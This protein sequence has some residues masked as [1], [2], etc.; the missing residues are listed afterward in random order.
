[1]AAVRPEERRVP[2]GAVRKSNPR[3]LFLSRWRQ[4]LKASCLTGLLL[5]A[6]AHGQGVP[7]SQEPVV[8]TADQIMFDTQA[9]E[10]IA[11]GD[12][13]LS[14]GGRRLLADQV[15]Y[16]ERDDIVRAAGNIVLLEPTGQVF[17]GDRLEVTG[18]LRNGFVEGLKAL[19]DERSRLAAARGVRRD[20]S[21]MILERAVYSPCEICAEGGAPLWQIKARQVTHDADSQ[22]VSYRNATFELFGVP[23][24]WTPY[25]SH[26]DPT[27]ERKTG[28]L[29]PSFGSDS[30]LGFTLETPFHYVI[31]PNR[32][33]TLTPL[34]TTEKGIVL[35]TEYRELREI[36]TTTLGGS[37]TRTDAYQRDPDEDGAGQDIRGHVEGEGRYR[38]SDLDAGFDLLLASD[39]TYLERYDF[40]DADVLE[41][42]VYAQHVLGLDYWGVHGYG[43]QGLRPDDDQ[44]LIPVVLPLAETRLH[45]SPLKWG[46]RATLDTSLVALTR[47][48]GLDTRRLSSEIGW[49]L[50]W[51]GPIG[52][53]LR[54]RLSFRGDVYN[55][56]GNPETFEGGR[57]RSEARLIPRAT[58]DWSW[59]LIG[60]TGPWQHVVEPLAMLTITPTGLNDDNIPNEDSRVF[61]LD[62]TN[63]FEPDRFTGRDLVDDGPHVAY[64]VRFESVGPQGLSISGV[65]G[66]SYQI[67]HNDAFEANSGIGP[68]F[69]DYVGRIDFRPSPL[70]DLA[71]RFRL[72]KQDFV[73]R[74]ND[75]S[76]F[77]GPPRLRF[78][79]GYLELSDEPSDLAPRSREELRAGV[80][81][82]M[83]DNLAIAAQTRLDLSE[84]EPVSHMAGV[85]YTNP[86]VVV[87]AGFERSYTSRGE[88]EDDTRF[89]VQVTL[90]NLGSGSAGSGLWE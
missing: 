52:D 55:Y 46:S 68:N 59:P 77:V 51:V 71:Y 74:R 15:Q 67:D 12:V 81:L 8:L 61:E 13:E 28:F 16:D 60:D 3:N 11:R 21:V 17:F 62:E 75:V 42:H 35:S 32:D 38:F 85:L 37:I 82:Q 18:D 40:S 41:N 30:L 26:P 24:A 90:T 78:N 76:L 43:F 9:G 31:A 14:R 87:A 22:T 45:S 44:G 54:F 70:I 39:N 6:S 1:V 7:P 69:S 88:L 20:G 4:L 79:I 57:T 53:L 58:L 10:I 66:Q 84:N 33:V 34:F 72:D 19:L 5:T 36:G 29:A 86:C 25:F 49:E 64:G 50:P 2:E 80:R 47:T 83:L 27:V 48:E 73:L 65:F 89:K 63:V 56:D 23:V